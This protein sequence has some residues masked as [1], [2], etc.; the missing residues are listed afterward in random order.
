MIKPRASKPNISTNEHVDK[1]ISI[2]VIFNGKKYDALIDTGA[3]NSCIWR[4]IAAEHGI[5]VHSM[6]GVISLTDENQTIPGIGQ[7]ESI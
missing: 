2:S 1:R 5:Q 7:T 6:P 4:D 3:T